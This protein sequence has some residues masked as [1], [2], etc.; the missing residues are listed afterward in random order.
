MDW[1][2]EELM[3]SERILTQLKTLFTGSLLIREIGASVDTAHKAIIFDEF[4]LEVHPEEDLTVLKSSL[5]VVGGNE[6]INAITMSEKGLNPNE[7]QQ[8]FVSDFN[9]LQHSNSA[10]LTD[11]EVY[12][13][14]IWHWLRFDDQ[15]Y[16]LSIRYRDAMKKLIK[17][18]PYLGFTSENDT[19]MI[20]SIGRLRTEFVE[21]FYSRSGAVHITANELSVTLIN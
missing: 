14:R 10:L 5:D 12:T 17:S 15:S 20:Q 7:L 9:S 16:K 3:D 8:S 18:T 19:D 21:L 1:L 2:V 13:F 6:R 11:Y 4:P